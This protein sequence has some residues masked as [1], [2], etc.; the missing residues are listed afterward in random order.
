MLDVLRGIALLGMFFVHF[1]DAA[2]EPSGGFGLAYRRFVE[3]F[4]SGQFYTM[5]AILF[6]AGFAVQLRRTRP[7]DRAFLLRYGRRLLALAVFGLIAEVL[8][9]YRVLLGYAIWSVPLL[10]V[11]RWSNR[12]LVIALI[13]CAASM[14]LQ[15]VTRAVYLQV[16]GTPEV[17]AVERRAAAQQD[18][19]ARQEYQ[20]SQRA[21]DYGT[22]VSGRL[23]FMPHTYTQTR[24]SVL[25]T[26]SFTYFLIGFL[27][28]RLGLF[29]ERQRHT[30]MIIAVM[31]FGALSWAAAH[32]LLPLPIKLPNGLPLRVAAQ[33]A[34]SG[35]SLIRDS[36]LALTYTGA[37]LLLVARPAWLRRLSFFSITG[38]MALTN[39]MLQVVILDLTFSNYAFGAQVSAWLTPVA[40][41]ALFGV[42]VAFSR[43]WLSRFYYGPLEWLWRCATYARW[44][45]FRCG[46]AARV[47]LSW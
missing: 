11:R 6:G 26:N 22:A 1:S 12:A 14:P 19:A 47:A 9:G 40:A 39:Y 23:R 41:L 25:P 33:T 17:F 38:R 4:F 21:S 44:Q 13:V 15:S 31:I 27:A 36:G 10:L 43:W 34:A 16:V 42:E 45:P 3:L 37:I 32:W 7:G 30:R 18:A 28:F 20:A 35:F 24:T 5:F 29:D 46:P 8:F 2:I